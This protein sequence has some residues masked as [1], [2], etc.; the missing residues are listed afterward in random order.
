MPVP[1]AA[2]MLG[3]LQ[4]HEFLT[5]PQVQQLRA[6]IDSKFADPR[7]LIRETVDRNWLTPY[8]A[9][10]LL[11][12]NGSNLLLGPYR[13]LDKLG[14]GGMGQVLK[15]F[16]TGMERTVALKVIAKDRVADPTA[17]ARFQREVRAV[18]TLSH[19]NIVVA[20]DVNQ[21][22]QTP[23]LAMEYVDGIDLSRLVRQS[24]PLPIA[25]ACD[26][27]RQ[28]ALGLQHAHEKGL[29]HRDIKPGNLVVARPHPDEPPI[30]KI[31]DFGLARFESESPHKGRLTRLGGVIGTV[32]YIAPE[33][34][35]NPLTADIRADIFSLGCTL[36]YLLTGTAPFGGNGAAE[37]ITARVLGNAPSV[38]RNRPEISPFLDLVLAKMMA[39]NPEDRYQTP[40]ELAMALEPHIAEDSQDSAAPTPEKAPARAPKPAQAE[41]LK[42]TIDCQPSGK[43][44]ANGKSQAGGKQT[45]PT[46][47]FTPEQ[48]ALLNERTL[49]PAT[50]AQ[51][52]RVAK[53][54]KSGPNAVVR[55]KKDK[56]AKGG[57]AWMA[58]GIGI[59]AILAVACA[60]GGGVLFFLPGLIGRPSATMPRVAVGTAVWQEPK[61]TPHTPSLTSPPTTAGTK[62][63][64][65]QQPAL[66][67]A[68]F[69]AQEAKASQAAWAKYLGRK[70]EEEIDLGGGVKLV[71]VL[72]PP[73]SFTMGSPAAEKE[74][75]DTE[76]AHPVTLTKPFYLG[77]YAVTQG[78]YEKLAVKDK[79]PSYFTKEKVGGMDT[80][81]FPV[82]SVSW[83]ATDGFC[84][85]LGPKVAWGKV[86]LPSEAQREYAC[87]AGTK[88]PFWFGSELNGKQANCY[89]YFRW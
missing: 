67:K 11:Q 59:F 83:D 81:A 82:E 14:E 5:P 74:R 39:R 63:V 43:S 18:A 77:K 50:V 45:R 78:Q 48:Q 53:P 58:L 25:R 76:G 16:H 21:V 38:R 72:I 29:V 30:I 66:L 23:F 6:G 62:P 2:E 7:A 36:Y 41:S 54:K 20:F 42:A 32:D 55:K 17:I 15:A 88:T 75:G 69:T 51:A 3:F 35:Q 57:R 56:P 9:N 60:S 49:L 89:G 22:G 12:G 85:A 70:V 71:L 34:A 1:N 33:Q 31:L 26:Y 24:G 64:T 80:A 19:H 68:P 86:G 44:Q 65:P 79:N 46:K 87:R 73:G 61:S 40:G 10:Q 8:Q 28:A 27:V 47:T 13:I 4:E 37:R 52:S 84:K